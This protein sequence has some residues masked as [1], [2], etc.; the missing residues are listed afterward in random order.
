MMSVVSRTSSGPAPMIDS[1]RIFGAGSPV[2]TNSEY[3]IMPSCG[4]APFAVI[5]LGD[6]LAAPV[7]PATGGK[8]RP[9]PHSSSCPATVRGR[10]AQLPVAPRGDSG[11]QSLLNGLVRRTAS[12]ARA[13][14]DATPR[15]L[16]GRG[17]ATNQASESPVTDR[18]L[19]R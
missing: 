6:Q 13:T 17:R 1:Y 12:A 8:E 15:E 9:Q 3:S 7:L 16:V 5:V 2:A 14:V 19:E 18:A 10:R 11:A 4:S